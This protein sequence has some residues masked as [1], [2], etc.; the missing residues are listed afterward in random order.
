MQ[1]FPYLGVL[2]GGGGGGGETFPTSRIFAHYPPPGKITAQNHLSSGSDHP[3]K[4][5]PTANIPNPLEFHP[6]TIF[7][8]PDMPCP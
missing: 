2:A 8:I 6:L 7:G 4:N 5:P 3:I 1:G